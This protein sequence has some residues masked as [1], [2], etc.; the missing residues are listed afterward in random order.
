MP[1]KELYR[2]CAD[3]MPPVARMKHLAGW[4]LERA[5]AEVL[6]ATPS[7]STSGKRPTAPKGMRAAAAAAKGEGQAEEDSVWNAQ[8]KKVL[9]R[10]RPS[11]EKVMLDTLRDLSD[12]KINISWLAAAAA[13]KGAAS[14]TPQPRPNPLNESNKALAEQL[15]SLVAALRSENARW[16]EERKEIEALE[17]QTASMLGAGTAA[18]AAAAAGTSRDVTSSSS[19]DAAASSSSAGKL[20]ELDWTADELDPA[21]SRMM[22]D[23]RRALALEEKW[24][25]ASAGASN[26]AAAAATDTIASAVRAAAATKR[27]AYEEHLTLQRKGKRKSDMVPR[28]EGDDDETMI[29]GTDLDPRWRDVEYRADVLHSHTHIA[30]RLSLLSSSYTS[31]ISARAAQALRQLA[32]APGDAAEA[33]AA[34]SSTI[35]AEQQRG[36]GGESAES[37]KAG[38]ERLE[39]ILRGVRESIGP[40]RRQ[41]IQDEDAEAKAMEEAAAAE[42]AAAEAGGGRGGRGA[43]AD[44]SGVQLAD[45]SAVDL[46]RAYASTKRSAPGAAGGAPA[47]GSSKGRKSA[48]SSRR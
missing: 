14:S 45:Q 41:E 4:T 7:A 36:T 43:G 37:R 5:R 19:N 9:E 20:A 35:A 22:Q 46:F 10:C 6:E 18:A 24:L 13:G 8:E 34:G 23:A 25:P 2:H 38:R 39:K 47:G 33:A 42:A 12:Q 1:D 30:D 21:M 27:K 31:S 28:P 29:A 16:E 32:F 11:L 44:D 40:V 48:R 15:S 3:N 17:E 26:E